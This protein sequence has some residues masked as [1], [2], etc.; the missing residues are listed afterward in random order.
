VEH[1]QKECDD[2]KGDLV[3]VVDLEACKSAL[4]KLPYFMPLEQNENISYRINITGKDE[5]DITEHVDKGGK[6]LVLQASQRN[7]VTK[8][9]SESQQSSSGDGLVE[10]SRDTKPS[11]PCRET[12]V[13][14]YILKRPQRKTLTEYNS[15]NPEYQAMMTDKFDNLA[16]SNY[17]SIF[18]ALT[19][20]LVLGIAVTAL[21]YNI[22]ES[23][24]GIKPTF[25]A[26]GAF[27]MISLLDAYSRV[28]QH[29]ASLRII[30][31]T[32][33][34]SYMTRIN[35]ASTYIGVLWYVLYGFYRNP[36][37]M[38]NFKNK[39]MVIIVT[40]VVGVLTIFLIRYMYRKFRTM[41]KHPKRA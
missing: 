17:D 8:A 39:I 7:M 21:K 1:A 2:E 27:I 25:I 23:S 20:L 4:H 9:S 3:I 26:I 30:T 38:N 36:N 16:K 28:I 12:A 37:V 35:V 11:L 24:E 33:W 15:A 13:K 18:W 14:T 19:W 31:K 41:K 40:A 22:E 10:G 5:L 34:F 29:L 32:N 6:Y